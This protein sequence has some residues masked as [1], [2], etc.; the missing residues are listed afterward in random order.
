MLW[1]ERFLYF[2]AT[3]RDDSI[4]AP[5]LPRDGPVFAHDCVELFLLGHADAGTYWELNFSPS[6]SLLDARHCHRRPKRGAYNPFAA[7]LEGLRFAKRLTG[8]AGKPN[9]YVVEAAI[10]LDQVP[11]W[12]GPARPGAKLYG[13]ITRVDK[14]SPHTDLAASSPVRGQFHNLW[15]HSPMTLVD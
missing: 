11:D 5:K 7:T 8:P 14:T 13:L 3:C 9:G 12:P 1:D 4:E 10:P 6:G 15:D 2:A